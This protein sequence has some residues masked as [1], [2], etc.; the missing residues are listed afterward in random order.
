MTSRQHEGGDVDAA[1]R[2]ALQLRARQAPMPDELFA[3]PR[4]WVRS[5]RSP[6]LVGR[7]LAL[8]ATAAG[9]TLLVTLVLTRIAPAPPS[10]NPV[11]DRAAA[12]GAF[13]ID[14][15]LAVQTAD[16][17]LALR[18]E[19]DGAA[20]IRL[21]LVTGSAGEYRWRELAVAQGRTD[22]VAD[23]YAYVLP[24]SCAPAA[25]LA[26][27]DLVFGYVRVADGHELV[28]IRPK[29]G[30]DEVRGRWNISP[31]GWHAGLFL[32]AMQPGHGPDPDGLDLLIVERYRV[33]RPI[34]GSDGV[35]V[36][37]PEEVAVPADSFGHDDACTGEV[38]G[39]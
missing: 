23:S 26:Q 2:H 11:D 12:L 29:A 21:G 1:L 10:G 32:Y 14:P 30:L 36:T 27:P 37:R 18:V 24:V 4:A 6:T 33:D 20:R 35:M 16:G 8:L 17:L 7:G 34:P 22:A 19:V 15:E 31:G 28:T 25:G 9:A 39:G 13:G 5:R 38:V 3:V